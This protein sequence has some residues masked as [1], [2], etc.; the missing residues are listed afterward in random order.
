M[1]AEQSQIGVIGLG[2]MGRNLILNIAEHGLRAAGYDKKSE[3]AAQLGKESGGLPV[4]PCE[5]YKSFIAALKKPRIVL[6]L[7]PAGKP[8]DSVLQE[9]L[10]FLSQGDIVI[11]A[12]NSF[13][14]DTNLRAKTFG[15]KG[16]HLLGV[17]V[18]GGEEGAR[19]GPSIMPGGNELAYRAVEPIFKAIAAKVN[20]EPCVAY[21]GA[22][23]AG[24]YVKM[25]HNGIEYG[26]ME[27]IAETYDVMDRG[28]DFSD[29]ELSKIYG[30][31]SRGLVNSF[32]VEIT[33]Q[34]FRRIDE[35]THKPL[36][37]LISDEAK[38][39]GTGMWTS[40]EA[41]RLGVPVPNIDTAVAMRDLSVFKTLRVE[42]SR[43][44]SG[45]IVEPHN[46]IDKVIDDLYKALYVS[47]I[48]TYSQGFALLLA[49]GRKYG[50]SFNPA[51]VA[52]IWRGG[53]IIRSAVL[54]QIMKAFE[55]EPN[56]VHLL[57]YPYF[58]G[59]VVAN[60]QSLRN[61]VSLAAQW[62][63]PVPGMMAALSYYDSLRSAWLPANLIQAQRDY[64]GSHT[65][66]RVDEKG[67][68]HTKWRE[69]EVAK[70]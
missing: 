65:Y 25:V 57:D 22:G 31:W 54:E 11:D 51:I 49:A 15:E 39:K 12:G 8:V 59:E 23:S 60:Q 45:P 48:L 41:M 53:C 63:I 27:L 26:L 52:K 66:E 2:V 47:M 64:F 5:N 9:L 33:A 34:I 6:I 50:Y 24:H 56:L 19:H 7:V 70:V 42:E 29:T 43:I 13:F 18:S 14:E 36:I 21:L 28:L 44:L 37:D 58:A 16:I 3:Q 17:G 30:G 67:T 40:Q 32:L 61:I 20:G 46:D 35:K 1:A 55:N 38:Q 69:T 4:T 10:P 68:F 62:G